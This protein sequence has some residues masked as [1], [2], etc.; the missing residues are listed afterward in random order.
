MTDFTAAGNTL[1]LFVPDKG[2][3]I[4]VAISGTYVMVIDLQI[5]LGSKG[6]GAWQNIKRFNTTNGTESFD[7]VTKSIGENL[8][9][10]L[11]TDT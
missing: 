10:F 9:L 4:H 2:E 5:E 3:T 8:R 11:R 1:E 7:Y 6:S